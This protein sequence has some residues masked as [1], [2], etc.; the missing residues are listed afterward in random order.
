MENI[1]IKNLISNLQHLENRLVDSYNNSDITFQQYEE[2]RLDVGNAIE[3]IQNQ[4]AEIEK[5]KAENAIIIKQAFAENRTTATAIKAE[6]EQQRRIAEYIKRLE[7]ARDYYKKNRDEYQ[8]KVMFI[9][10]LCDEIQAELETAKTEAYKEFAELSKERLTGWD[11]DPTD[12]E[13]EDTLD[14]VLEELTE[15][16]ED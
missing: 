13:I 12:E 4:Q 2:D 11:T 7:N 14:Y 1:D 15:R 8:D 10:N 9:A 16:K 6:L 5:L 3:L